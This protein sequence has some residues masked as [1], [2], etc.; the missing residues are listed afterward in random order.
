MDLVEGLLREKKTGGA[1]VTDD[2]ELIALI[3][4]M[5]MPKHFDVQCAAMDKLYGLFATRKDMPDRKTFLAAAIK[6]YEWN[7]SHFDCWDQK[8]Y[9]SWR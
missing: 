5:P 2:P 6:R 9:R 3:A 8:A 1:T 4:A 7:A